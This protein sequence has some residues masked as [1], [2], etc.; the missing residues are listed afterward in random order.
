MKTSTI[1]ISASVL[2]GIMQ[3]RGTEKSLYAL[4]CIGFGMD[5]SR[6]S[7]AVR[8]Y[9]A[10]G[11]I[12][13]TGLCG[14]IDGHRLPKQGVSLPPEIYSE[15]T[16]LGDELA[17]QIDHSGS[18]TIGNGMSESK[19]SFNPE[20]KHA[21][22][23]VAIPKKFGGTWEGS[24]EAIPQILLEC[25]LLERVTKGLSYMLLGDPQA[26]RLTFFGEKAPIV[27]TSWTDFVAVLMPR[28]E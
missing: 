8:Y 10:D 26:I 12:G 22:V 27:I 23:L 16:T 5:K 24:S 18:V 25:G 9:A 1:R 21:P 15:E 14:E 2:K 11:H 4:D 17:L 3:F 7:K 20:D 6:G 19:V 13:I 28:S